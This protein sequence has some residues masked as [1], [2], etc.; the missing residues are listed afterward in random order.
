MIDLTPLEVRLKKGDFRRA[1]RGYDPE[2]V[3]DFLDLISDRMEELVKQNM[4]LTE[5]VQGL[6]SEVASYRNKERALSDAL[7]TA[8]RLREDAKTHAQKEGELMVREARMAAEVA[9]EEAARALVREENALRQARARRAEL[10]SSFRQLLQR[11]LSEL[12]VIEEALELRSGGAAEGEDSGAA[13]EVAAE[14]QARG[15]EDRAAGK[16]GTGKPGTGETEG[17][18]AEAGK[19]APGKTA[20][21][22]TDA[23]DTPEAGGGASG[24]G[25]KKAGD[26]TDQKDW[27]SSLVED[28][29]SS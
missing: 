29:R 11:E 23:G 2:L 5:S 25:G 9:R 28:S 15:G 4:A 20:P 6:E 14:G 3:D 8:Q 19:A 10:I 24:K 17:G 27:L 7:M 22:K 18:K 26:E 16:A 21:G 12:D 1:F 13:D